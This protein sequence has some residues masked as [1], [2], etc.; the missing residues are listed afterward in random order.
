MVKNL[1]RLTVL[2]LT[3]QEFEDYYISSKHSITCFKY[4]TRFGINN[5]EN[6]G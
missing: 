6:A 5:L 3:P 2:K 4:F 1:L